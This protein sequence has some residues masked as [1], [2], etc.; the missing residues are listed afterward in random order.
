MTRPLVATANGYFVFGMICG[1]VLGAFL[2]VVVD[3]IA[4]DRGRVR[5]EEQRDPEDWSRP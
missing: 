3:L 4:G 1:V 2:A 5:I